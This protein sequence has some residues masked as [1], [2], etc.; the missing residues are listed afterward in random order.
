MINSRFN[1]YIHCIAISDLLQILLRSPT[2]PS[3]AVWATDEFNA[4]FFKSLFN[5]LKGFKLSPGTPLADSSLCMEEKPTPDFSA[6]SMPG[7]AYSSYFLLVIILLILIRRL[8][9][10]WWCLIRCL[11]FRYWSWWCS[12][13]RRCWIRFHFSRL[14]W[15]WWCLN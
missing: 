13:F 5:S 9:W 1:T 10:I 11:G 2:H 3:A 4:G 6:R 7:C 12:G 14:F 8:C 15:I